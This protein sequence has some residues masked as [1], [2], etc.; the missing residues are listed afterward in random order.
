[1]L[2]RPRAFRAAV[3]NAEQ[4]QGLTPLRDPRL[5]RTRAESKP[6][7][8]MRVWRDGFFVQYDDMPSI[9]RGRCTARSLRLLCE[10]ASIND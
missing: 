5:G 2:E 9:I 6:Q 10:C 3:Y 4:I 1:M 7:N 8:E